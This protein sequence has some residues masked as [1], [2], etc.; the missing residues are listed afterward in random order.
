[1]YYDFCDCFKALCNVC[2]DKCY[3]NKLYYHHYYVHFNRITYS[4]T[5]LRTVLYRDDHLNW[6]HS[7]WSR[8]I[9]IPHAYLHRRCRFQSDFWPL[10]HVKQKA[11]LRLRLSPFPLYCAVKHGGELPKQ[12]VNQSFCECR[13]ELIGALCS[14][15]WPVTRVQLY[16]STGQWGHKPPPAVSAASVLLMVP[17]SCLRA[18][19]CVCTACTRSSL[20]NF[21]AFWIT[22]CKRSKGRLKNN[23]RRRGKQQGINK[24][25]RRRNERERGTETGWLKNSWLRPPCWV[26]LVPEGHSPAPPL[27]ST[28]A[29]AP[30]SNKRRVQAKGDQ[31][32]PVVQVHTYCTPVILNQGYFYC[33]GGTS[34]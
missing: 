12:P 3:T 5:Q 6:G 28:A 17:L 20:H 30:S 8:L 31:G 24:D 33:T 15:Y 13:H 7:R 14:T 19:L 16:Y 34:A 10:L 26:L 2:F 9:C 11:T 4:V 25:K 32:C 1:M 22:G 18:C 29:R 21:P 27:N 23:E